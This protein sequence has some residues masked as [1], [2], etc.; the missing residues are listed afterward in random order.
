MRI[1]DWSSNVCSSDLDID[2]DIVM[3]LRAVIQR[4]LGYIH[5]GFGIVAIHV[6]H[7]RFDHLDHVGAIQRGTGVARVG[8]GKADLVIADDVKRAAGTVPDPFSPMQGF[9]DSSNELRGGK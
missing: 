7:R 2:H 9:Y 4:Q 1:S 5:D 8:G 6:E 3:E